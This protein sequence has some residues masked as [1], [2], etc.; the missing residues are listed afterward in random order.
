MVFGAEIAIPPKLAGGEVKKSILVASAA[1]TVLVASAAQTVGGDAMAGQETRNA[2]ATAEPQATVRESRSITSL[3]SRKQRR[4]R[5]K[6]AG[7]PSG[8]QVVVQEAGKTA[9]Q[10]AA[11]ETKKADILAKPQAVQETEETDNPFAPAKPQ[12]VAQETEETDNPFAPAKPQAVAQETKPE[13]MAGKKYRMAPIRWR[14]LVSETLTWLQSSDSSSGLNSLSNSRSSSFINAQT[15]EIRAS[16]YIVQPYIAKVRGGFGVIS[17]STTTNSSSTTS[18]TSKS[19]GR[20]NRLYGD[21]VLSL[22]SQS[23]FPFNMEFGVY[24]R[25]ANLGAANTNE[26]GKMLMLSQAYRP[27]RSHSLYKGVYRSSTTSG[28]SIGNTAGDS[29]TSSFSGTYNTFFG[30]SQSFSAG[31]TDSKSDS[32]YGLN[33]TTR[34]FMAAHKYLPPASLLSLTT[35]A[36]LIQSSQ[37]QSNLNA[38]NPSLDSRYMQANTYVS[39]QPEAEDV[40][41]FVSGSGQFLSAL[42]TRDAAVSTSRQNLGGSIAAVYNASRNLTYRAGG[43]ATR[44]SRDGTRSLAT[45]QNG[46]ISYRADPV[47]FWNKS[48]Y[49]WGTSGSVVN[50]T[51]DNRSTMGVSGAANHS[52][53]GPFALNF[54]GKK[55]A[56]NYSVTQVLTGSSS[57]S[58]GFG[59]TLVNSGKA[60]M[61]LTDK[62]GKWTGSAGAFLTDTHRIGVNPGNG[63]A[64]GIQAS[65]SVYEGYGAKAGMMLEATQ[66]QGESLRTKVMGQASYRK[67]NL[68]GVR[69]LE[70]RGGLDLTMQTQQFNN[71]ASNNQQSNVSYRLNQ[72]L[73]YR[74]GL[75]EMQLTSFLGEQYGVKSASLLL[76]FRAW[77]GVGGTVQ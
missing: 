45:T 22:F 7:V 64:F 12:A 3:Q 21:G 76:L 66:V 60:S 9:P 38:S 23:R 33:S 54:F 32:S 20:S 40:P 77:R 5:P 75:N 46:N 19:H 52:L 73:N 70:Y 72:S 68:F 41:L 56:I 39:W 26:V 48:S 58:R 6:M 67:R 4:R 53:G 65:E 74:I 36:S 55:K 1:Q 43:S 37:G 2:D 35:N 63:R 34:T 8:L 42:T 13:G 10:V 16:S 30:S 51:S 59:G 49:V 31:V 28:N 57:Q 24:D 50:T 11:Q 44:T 18:I 27:L 17:A 25:N 47:G 69:G 62:N 14:A 15:A 71:Y 29:R 61:G